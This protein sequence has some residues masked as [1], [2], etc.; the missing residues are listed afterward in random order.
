MVL[1]PGA[2][3][4]CGVSQHTCLLHSLSVEVLWVRKQISVVLAV[5]LQAETAHDRCS[6]VHLVSH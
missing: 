2:T 5:T 3:L 4:Y 1:C 6:A